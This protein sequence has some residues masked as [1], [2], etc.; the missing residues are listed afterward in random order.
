MKRVRLIV[1]YRTRRGVTGK[2]NHKKKHTHTHKTNK[3]FYRRRLVTDSFEIYLRFVSR[4][5]KIG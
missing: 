2:A 1:I 4:E 3:K 5:L